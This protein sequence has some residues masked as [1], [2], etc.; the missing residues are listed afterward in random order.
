MVVDGPSCSM[1][2]WGA[3]RVAF[4]PSVG[5]RRP[6]NGFYTFSGYFEYYRTLASVV[7]GGQSGGP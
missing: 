1:A 5:L 2:R 7:P 4:D 6:G 3:T